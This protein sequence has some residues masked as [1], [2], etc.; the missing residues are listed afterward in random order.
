MTRKEAMRQTRQADTLRALGF[1]VAEADALRRISV[2]LHRWHELECG[3]GEGQTTWS[4]ERDGDEP[5]S[6]PYKRVQ[7]PSAHGYVDRRWPIPDRETGARK[8]LQAIIDARNARPMPP[9]MR[10]GVL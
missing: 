6:K 1:T 9:D 8:R 5:D 7:Y 10:P 4:I 2:T 3:T